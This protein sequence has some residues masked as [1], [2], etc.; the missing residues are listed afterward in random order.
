MPNKRIIYQCEQPLIA[1]GLNFTAFASGHV[2]HGVQSIGMNGSVPITTIKE[3]G[4]ADPYEQMEEVSDINISMEK[5]ID[6]Y[7]LIYHKATSD[8]T[9]PTLLGRSDARCH[10]GLAIFPM[11]QQRSSGTAD[12][13]CFHSG[14][15]PNN[16]GIELPVQGPIRETISFV[17]NNRKWYSATYRNAEAVSINILSGYFTGSA[18]FNVPDAPL[19]ASGIMK[20][21]DVLFDYTSSY[22][23][24]SNGLPVYA[25]GCTFPRNIPGMD[26]SGRNPSISSTSCDYS[27]K[28]QSIRFSVPLNRTDIYELGCKFPYDRSLNPDI[29][30]TT[31]IEIICTSGDFIEALETGLY[32]NGD[33]TRDESIRVAIRDGTRISAGTKNRM[34]GFST[35]GGGSDGTN[36]SATY[37][38]QTTNVFDILHPADPKFG[39]YQSGFSLTGG[40]ASGHY[41]N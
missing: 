18:G 12:F 17:G 39:Q 1:P 14:Y 25:S 4:Q 29:T 15:Y 5:C 7:P 20:R 21:E 30:V 2:V 37:T 3:L 13:A 35:A 34:N 31:E 33:N 10:I 11:T 38:Y 32:A 24:D 8:A 28:L 36:M 22:A 19:A 16:L 23:T 6:G 9:Y 40:A 41:F 27:V 26:S